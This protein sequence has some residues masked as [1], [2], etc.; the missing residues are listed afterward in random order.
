MKQNSFQNKA[1]N[2]STAGCRK[3]PSH[4]LLLRRCGGL[5]MWYAKAFIACCAKKHDIFNPQKKSRIFNKEPYKRFS[6]EALSDHLQITQHQNAVA[7]EMLQRVSCFQKMLDEHERVAKD[8]LVNMFTAGYW[9]MK[10]ELPN[11][12]IKSLLLR[13]EQIRM[14]DMKHFLQRSQG[15]LREIFLILG[16]TVQDTCLSKVKQA[17]HFGF[18]VD[19]LA[20]ISV[21]EQM[22]YFTQ[23]YNKSGRAVKTGLLSIRTFWKI[24][25]WQR[26]V[27]SLTALSKPWIS[28]L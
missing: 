5:C 28:L 8:V 4:S 9:L 1:T 15:A 21:T 10:V 2:L 20:V 19:D 24:H 26:Q 3:D 27:P 13:L 16:K 11:H 6:P 14:S 18:L 25:H 17:V 22:I 23:F 12:K 7:A